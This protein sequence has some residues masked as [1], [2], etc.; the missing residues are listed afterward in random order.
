MKRLRTI[1]SW[2]VE[3]AIVAVLLWKHYQVYYLGWYDLDAMWCVLP[4]SLVLLACHWGQLRQKHLP[5][6][7]RLKL[8]LLTGPAVLLCLSLILGLT[9]ELNKVARFGGVPKE[10][11]AEVSRYKGKLPNPKGGNYERRVMSEKL[12]RRDVLY[13]LGV[14]RVKSETLIYAMLL[15]S[16]IILYG[17][18]YSLGRLEY[19]EGPPASG[20]EK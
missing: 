19:S 5:K 20:G 11:V 2:T 18:R 14:E 12:S 9:Y 10:V 7:V 4:A 1:V 13:Y 8:L 6:K 17:N 16:T 15:A 3:L